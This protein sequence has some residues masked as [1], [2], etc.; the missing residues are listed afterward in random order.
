MYQR[1]TKWIILRDSK[2][3]DIAGKINR[4][5]MERNLRRDQTGTSLTKG[6]SITK[7]DL[8]RILGMIAKENKINRGRIYC[9]RNT[10]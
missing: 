5:I 10:F 3:D 7:N 8:F 2:V 1:L 9:R 4:S 6:E